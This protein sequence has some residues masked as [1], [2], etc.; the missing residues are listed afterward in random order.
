MPNEMT[1]SK[2]KVWTKWGTDR[3]SVGPEMQILESR[4]LI[5]YGVYGITPGLDKSKHM[6]ILSGSAGGCMMA[7]PL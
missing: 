2:K 1:F 4:S 5:P 3:V 6:D 7:H